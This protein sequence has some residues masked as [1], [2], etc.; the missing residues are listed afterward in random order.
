M[1]RSIITFVLV[2]IG[3]NLLFAL[4]HLDIRISIVGS[5]L[6]SFLVSGIMEFTRRR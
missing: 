4:L 2:L 3:L 5:L 6:L 1:F